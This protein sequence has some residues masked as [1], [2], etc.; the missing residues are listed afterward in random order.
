MGQLETFD[1]EGCAL[2]SASDFMDGQVLP[3]TLENSNL[4]IMVD[5]VNNTEFVTVVSYAAEADIV[6]P[7]AYACNVSS[8]PSSYL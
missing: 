3:T 5:E 6:T 4:T 8:T 1:R 2:Q 7:A